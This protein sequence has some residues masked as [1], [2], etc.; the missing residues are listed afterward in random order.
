MK[1]TIAVMAVLLGVAFLSGCSSKNTPTN[2]PSS[3]TSEQTTT[4]NEEAR[5]K[6][7]AGNGELIKIS[8]QD[9]KD[10]ADWVA[11]YK[12]PQDTAFEKVDIDWD[13]DDPAGVWFTQKEL[14]F[15]T[16]SNPPIDIDKIEKEIKEKEGYVTNG[17]FAD[18]IDLFKKINYGEK[19]PEI[20]ISVKEAKNLF[21]LHIPILNKF[22]NIVNQYY[23]SRVPKSELT[24][25]QQNGSSMFDSKMN[26]AADI[27][28]AKA[29]P[30]LAGLGKPSFYG[31]GDSA[32]IRR[33]GAIVGGGEPNIIYEFIPLTQE[34]EDT[35]YFSEVK[36]EDG[37]YKKTLIAGQIRIKATTFEK[38]DE[39]YIRKTVKYFDLLNKSGSKSYPFLAGAEGKPELFSYG[40]SGSGYTGSII[41]ITYQRDNPKQ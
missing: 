28:L 41:S 17:N 8:E 12:K 6:S 16:V 11:K 20:D 5:L 13:Y 37:F 21:S 19:E 22:I 14:G 30:F 34:G 9:K 23:P 29:T 7:L 26:H 38:V 40:E 3:Q 4:Q 32:I 24:N 15:N 1:K 39:N 18:R 31:V 35:S 2:P 25:P 27:G 10:I 36:Y 33:I